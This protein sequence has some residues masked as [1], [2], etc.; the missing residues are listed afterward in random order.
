M[1]PKSPNTLGHTATTAGEI[2]SAPVIT[3]SPD[4]SVGDVAELLRSKDISGVPVVDTAGTLLGLVSEYDLL[5]KT[6][7]SARDVMTTSVISVSADTAIADV[8]H[9]LV[10]RR[11]RRVPVVV[12]GQLVGIVSR[13]DVVALLAT[14]WVCQVCGEAVRGDHPPERC[15]RCHSSGDHFVLEEQ[16]PGF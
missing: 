11:I 6:G 16:S 9:L 1:S 4:E 5:A 3:V 14:E 13:G 12:Q 7:E 10:D 8:R 2:M 15:P